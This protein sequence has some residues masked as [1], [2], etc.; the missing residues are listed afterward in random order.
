MTVISVS[1]THDLLERLDSFVESSGYSSR[2]EAIR[3][4]IRDTLTQF[5]LQRLEKGL[6]VA[7]VTVISERERHDINSRLIELGHEFEESIFSNMHLH[8]DGGQCVE[9]FVVR[10]L[11][12]VVLDFISKV[13]A[14][15]GIREVKYTMTPVE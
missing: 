2:S 11:S 3:L 14:V 7:T 1:L 15:R 8:I 4:A 10:G 6:V 13:R 12:E 9:I 5:A